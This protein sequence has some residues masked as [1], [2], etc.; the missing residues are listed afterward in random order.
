MI[1]KLVCTKIPPL[2][3]VLVDRNRTGS[4]IT[5]T[6]TTR[7]V[8]VSIY[9]SRIM[10]YNRHNLFLFCALNSC[11]RAWSSYESAQRWWHVAN[12]NF[13]RN[14]K[15]K[16]FSP[17][18]HRRSINH[19]CCRPLTRFAISRGWSNLAATTGPLRHAA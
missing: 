9:T 4:L 16:Q 12:S 13:V 18:F 8:K 15:A 2:Q 7:L 1:A 6:V 17:Y 11:R 5:L 14:S 10:R 3:I 19:N